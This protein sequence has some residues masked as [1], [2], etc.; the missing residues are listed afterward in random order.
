MIDVI[1]ASVLGFIIGSFA[2]IL[3]F[4]FILDMKDNWKK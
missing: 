4:L 1:I 3:V 2:V